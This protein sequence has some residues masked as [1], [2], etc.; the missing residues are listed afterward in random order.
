MKPVII[1]CFM[2]ILLGLSACKLEDLIKDV[3][4][5]EVSNI[6]SKLDNFI[7]NPGDTTL[8]WVEATDPQDETLNYLWTITVGEIIG[9]AQR[10]TLCWKAPLSGGKFPVS[11]KVSNSKKSV[12][13]S[14]N[15]TVLSF[16]R[17]YVKI[18]K[19]TSNDYLVQY[20]PTTI[21]AQ[22]FHEN[23]LTQV[24]LWINDSL[25]AGQSGAAVQEYQ[26][27]WN[28][29]GPAGLTEIKVT[30]VSK[31][32]ALI[33]ADSISIPLEGIVRGKR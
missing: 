18:L 10:D 14:E 32:T 22:A 27:N 5:P 19:P 8:F 2:F 21:T 13:K 30:A 11:I 1:F 26:F 23:G 4:P 7:I 15:I 3:K 16:I 17:P 6:N 29:S 28:G 12:T 20:Q 25:I 31:I 9:S 24:Q 33:G